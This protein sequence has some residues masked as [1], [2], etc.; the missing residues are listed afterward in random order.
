MVCGVFKSERDV[1]CVGVGKKPLVWI[2][3]KT[4]SINPNK[5]RDRHV[6]RFPSNL[7]VKVNGGLT[8]QVFET[9]GVGLQI[10]KL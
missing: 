5:S 9:S 7:M 2:E 3:G 8:L 10:F 4:G 6:R 1:S